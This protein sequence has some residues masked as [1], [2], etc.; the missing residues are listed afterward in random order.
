MLG[1][2]WVYVIRHKGHH[3]GRSIQQIARDLGVSRNTV[4]KYVVEGGEPRRRAA[5]R[6]RP[7]LEGGDD[8]ARAESAWRRGGVA[9]GVQ[10]HAEP[11]A[12]GRASGVDGIVAQ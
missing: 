4:R 1:M 8:D 7:V 6:P 2:D 11:A 9:A 5:A 3:E 10:E 12:G